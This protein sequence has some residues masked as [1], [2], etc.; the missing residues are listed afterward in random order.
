MESILFSNVSGLL[1]HTVTAFKELQAA[2]FLY[3]W[4]FAHFHKN[5]CRYFFR[6][7][8]FIFNPFSTQVKKYWS[9]TVQN[10]LGQGLFKNV[11]FVIFC[12]LLHIFCQVTGFCNKYSIF[13]NLLFWQIIKFYASNVI[14]FFQHNIIFSK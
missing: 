11:Q 10:F 1:L 14:D 9:V 13:E 8:C 3:K 12:A 4:Y 5:K 7:K 6:A 2:I